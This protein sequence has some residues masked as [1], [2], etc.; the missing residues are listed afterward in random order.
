MSISQ[1]NAILNTDF[2]LK[3]KVKHEGLSR[4]IFQSSKTKLAG[5]TQSTLFSTSPILFRF[6]PV[7]L[8]VKCCHLLLFASPSPLE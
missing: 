6:L 3:C 5:L 2:F 1:F 4:W 7:Q 8:F